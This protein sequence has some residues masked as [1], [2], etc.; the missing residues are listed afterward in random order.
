MEVQIEGFTPHSN[1]LEKIKQIETDGVKYIVLTTG[2]QYGKT[3]LAENLLLKWALENNN[4]NV[5]WIS[6]VYS[7]ARK[8]FNDIVNAI[9]ASPI[10]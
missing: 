1:Q 2:R 3:L 10:L 9:D 5:M 8:V 7:Q 4:S 6:P